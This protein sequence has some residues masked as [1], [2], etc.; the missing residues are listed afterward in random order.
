VVVG[1]EDHPADEVDELGFRAGDLLELLHE[2]NERWWA[3]RHKGTGDRGLLCAKGYVSEPLELRPGETRAVFAKDSGGWRRG[4]AS[5]ERAGFVS[6]ALD[7]VRHQAPAQLTDV[8]MNDALGTRYATDDAIA[9]VEARERNS[10]AP[11]ITHE[12][13]VRRKTAKRSWVPKVF[14]SAPAPPPPPPSQHDH[15]RQPS[16]PPPV[17]RA[18]VHDREVAPPSRS[19]SPRAAP[20]AR[21]TPPRP[22]PRATS[23]PSP[24]GG[25]A[26][27]LREFLRQYGIEHLAEDFK[28]RGIRRREDLLDVTYEEISNMGLNLAETLALDRCLDDVSA[29]AAAF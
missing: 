2:H 11:E 5:R 9:A 13:V 23:R 3:A 18:N 15:Y 10:G 7:G 14:S 27:G 29:D 19:S 28:S 12:P 6:V 26:T 24:G 22:P 20:A 4:V 17:Y 8:E 21:G 1:L 25:A 16:P